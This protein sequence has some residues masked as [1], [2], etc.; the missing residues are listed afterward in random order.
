VGSHPVELDRGGASDS[1]GGSRAG[2]TGR[3]HRGDS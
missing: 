3:D 2:S 1:A